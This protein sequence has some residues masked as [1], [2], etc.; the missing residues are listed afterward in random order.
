MAMLC[1]WGVVKR[2][3]GGQISLN[4]LFQVGHK[5]ASEGD[6]FSFL[7]TQGKDF[8]LKCQ[9]KMLAKVLTFHL[10]PGHQSV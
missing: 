6:T 9:F 10:F 3:G 8:S 1:T 2:E 4:Y 5:L 7:S